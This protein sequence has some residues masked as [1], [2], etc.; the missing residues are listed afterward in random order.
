MYDNCRLYGP[1][2][3]FMAF[4]DKKRFNWYLKKG[5][6]NQIDDKSIQLNFSPKGTGCSERGQ[7]LK[8]P[9]QS[10]CVVCGTDKDLT[11]HHVVPTRFRK[12]FPVEIKSH[13]SF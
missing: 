13:A 11:K 1:D 12:H 6:A 7:Y 4:C 3:L 9:R 2:G 10:I 5:L 8:T